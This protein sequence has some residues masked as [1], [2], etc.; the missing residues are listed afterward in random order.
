MVQQ[1]NVNVKSLRPM[2]AAGI[3]VE[4]LPK[5]RYPKVLQV[6]YDGIR[7]VCRQGNMVSRSGKLLPNVYIQQFFKEVHKVCESFHLMDGELI[8]GQPNDASVCMNTTSGVMS[9]GGEPDFT[10]YVFDRA[11]A[12][13]YEERREQISAVLD[14]LPAEFRNRIKLVGDFEVSGHK[15]VE[16]YLQQ[17]FD[18]D[19]EGCILRSFESPYKHGR[20]TVKQEYLLK[21]KDIRDSEAVVVG[22]E[23]LQT[24]MNEAQKSELGY[25]TRSSHQDGKIT[26]DSLGA[27][28]VRATEWRG[29]F[30]VGTG[31]TRAQ[32]DRMWEARKSLWGEYIKFKYL[33]AGMKDLPRH[34]VF[35]GFRSPRDMD[36]TKVLVLKDLAQEHKN[37]TLG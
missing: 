9:I 17:F 29:C 34:P 25:T 18:D 37:N 6:K 31:F 30:R 4:Q 13:S 15:E 7:A 28:I 20:S 8:V 10:F 32:R 22:F 3:T 5:L 14:R 19:L 27:L 36:A 12:Y 21:L 33:F 1:T 11:I 35:L 2:L 24:N 26:Q 23:P 16:Q